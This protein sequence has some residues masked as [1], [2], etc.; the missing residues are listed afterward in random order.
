[1][2]FIKHIWKYAFW[3]S[4]CSYFQKCTLRP[5][6][7]EYR[8]SQNVKVVS[9]VE[10]FPMV[11]VV[12]QSEF[13]VKCYRKNTVI[14]S[15]SFSFSLFLSTFFL[16]RLHFGLG[17]SLWH[18]SSM[19]FTADQPKYDGGCKKCP[20]GLQWLKLK[21]SICANGREWGWRICEGNIW[22][23]YPKCLS[24]IT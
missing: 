1:M 4:S 3:D 9:F 8:K 20:R 2:L 19:G 21:C 12:T 14:F 17:N 18:R 10:A 13:K 5:N 15:F 23:S 6:Y 16:L 7:E 11:Q 22:G 24:Q